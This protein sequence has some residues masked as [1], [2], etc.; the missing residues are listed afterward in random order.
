[1]DGSG[2]VD[3]VTDMLGHI[4]TARLAAIVLP[5]RGK[6][7]NMRGEGHSIVSPCERRRA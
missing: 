2:A 1:M 4:N 3:D 7:H 6:R 5:V